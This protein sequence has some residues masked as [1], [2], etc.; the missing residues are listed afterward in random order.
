[1]VFPSFLFYKEWSIRSSRN[2]PVV[3]ER[4]RFQGE[5]KRGWTL[6]WEVPTK[7]S[8][9]YKKLGDVKSL[10]IFIPNP[11]TVHHPLPLYI[12]FCKCPWSRYIRCHLLSLA[13][14]GL[15]CCR[16]QSHIMMWQSCLLILSWTQGNLK[17]LLQFWTVPYIAAGTCGYSGACWLQ[18]AG[19]IDFPRVHVD[20]PLIRF[21]TFITSKK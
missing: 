15:E 12:L 11:S 16:E 5:Q 21:V 20:F 14:V 6:W 19:N 13:V 4:E 17:L 8:R 2:T 9:K 1:M 3:T 18:F 7:T 10:S